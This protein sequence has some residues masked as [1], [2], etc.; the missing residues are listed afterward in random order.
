MKKLV[1]E[2]PLSNGLT[3]RCFDATRRYFGDYHQVRLE[4]CCEVAVTADLFA[5][6]REHES[7][8]K[9][10]GKSVLYR[11]H[12]EHQGVATEQIDTVRERMLDQFVSHA[13]PYFGGAGFAR[14]LVQAEL[15]KKA[16]RARSFAGRHHV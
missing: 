4:I 2:I 5:D 6:D 12:E 3:V 15:A 14:R 11:R 10:L 13:L 8:L 1:R 7:A 16:G 9:L